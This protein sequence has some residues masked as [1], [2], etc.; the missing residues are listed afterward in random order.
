[1][2]MCIKKES[3]INSIISKD[4]MLKFERV[5]LDK[6]KF[7][8]TNKVSPVILND[9]K[10]SSYNPFGDELT[11]K[12]EGFLFQKKTSDTAIFDTVQIPKDWWEAVKERFFP[13]F[14]LLRYPVKYRIIQSKIVTN[15]TKTCPHLNIASDKDHIDFLI[16][17]EDY[18]KCQK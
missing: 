1:M 18:C 5:V 11:I 6:V 9:L 15:I 13:K 14:L 17:K 7:N 3:N 12:L 2:V 10:I 4:D 16:T 8:L